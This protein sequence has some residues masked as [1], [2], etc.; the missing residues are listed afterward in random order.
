MESLFLNRGSHFLAGGASVRS[1]SDNELA[2]WFA[3]GEI[4]IVQVFQTLENIIRWSQVNPIEY[5]GV[6]W[7]QEICKVTNLSN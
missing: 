3:K 7:H 2:G 4:A 6:Q 5:E 1:F